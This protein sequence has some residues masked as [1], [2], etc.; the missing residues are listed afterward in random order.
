MRFLGSPR[1]R[2]RLRWLVVPLAL[3]P[4]VFL[5]IH[6]STPAD[7][8]GATG[9][10]VAALA[11]PKP[12]PFTHAEQLAVQPVLKEFISDA[13]ARDDVAR[14]WNVAGPTL[15]AGMTREQW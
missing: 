3:V 15:R 14:A 4:L 2:R 11:Q 12:S 10:E 8:G 13:V 9:P 7:N 5:G 6:Y 1:R